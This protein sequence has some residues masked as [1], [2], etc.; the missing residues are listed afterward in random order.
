MKKRCIHENALENVVYEISAILLWPGYDD[1]AMVKQWRY[2][3]Y[4]IW[5]L[6]TSCL[7]ANLMNIACEGI[8]ILKAW[9]T[10]LLKFYLLGF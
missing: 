8:D 1:V 4:P 5:V 6:Y 10:A 9:G 7:Q 2:I 3:E